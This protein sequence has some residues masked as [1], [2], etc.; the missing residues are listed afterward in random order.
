MVYNGVSLKPMI[1]VGTGCQCADAD[2]TLRGT[3]DSKYLEGQELV[4]S[5]TQVLG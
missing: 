4:V 3:G 2:R 5:F 1:H